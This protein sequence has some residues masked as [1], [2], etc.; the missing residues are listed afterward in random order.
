MSGAGRDPGRLETLVLQVQRMGP[1]SLLVRGGL[2][3]AGLVAEAVAWPVDVTF[4]SAAPLLLVAAVLPVV[5]PRT[6][7]VTAFLLSAIIGWLV[8]TTAYG[9]PLP[10]WRLVVLAAALY[11]VHT[12]A[13][14]AAVLPIDAVV[15][16]G[17]LAQWLVRAGG[18]VGLTAVV[19]LFT[20]VI[21]TYLGG[22]R[23]LVASLLGLVAM[24]GLGWYLAT[25]VRR[26]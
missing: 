3:L 24:I 21:P 15:A 6:R 10:Y 4:S 23:Y 22:Q 16:P 7:I 26:R 14:L 1:G 5:A 11:G 20:L 17:V 25:L 12:L 19:A 13:A 9:E 18:V 8:A 2:F